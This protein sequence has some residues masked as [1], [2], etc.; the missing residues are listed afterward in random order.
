[1]DGALEQPSH[2]HDQTMTD[3]HHDNN[4]NNNLQEILDGR[5]MAI[6][7]KKQ[8]SM[9]DFLSLH[10]LVTSVMA[11]S[12]SRLAHGVQIKMA[13]DVRPF[14]FY[15]AEWTRRV[16]IRHRVH[17]KNEEAP[18]LLSPAKIFHHMS[19]IAFHDQ[20]KKVGRVAF[21]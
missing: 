6:V 11:F 8:S 12:S 10:R 5:S 17:G 1:M 9:S 14:P 16:G 15:G 7:Q 19:P 21:L 18:T 3:I 2:P 13:S 4:N 20:V